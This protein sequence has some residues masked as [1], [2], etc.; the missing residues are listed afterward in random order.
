M[1]IKR[2]NLSCDILVVGGGIGGLTCAVSLKEQLPDADILVIEKQTAGYG[3]KAN[4]GGGVLQYF[5]P[6]KVDPV[7]FLGF[8]VNAIG[9][10]L[11]DQELMLKYVKMNKYMLDTLCGWGVNVPKKED[12]SYHVMP[13]G[14]FTAMI[15]VD[16]DITLRIRK[17]AEKLGVRFMDKTT[18]SDLFTQDGKIV[19]AAAYSILDGTYYAISAKN[20]VLATGSQNYRVG[21]M[22]SSGRGDGIAAAYRA[23]AEMR[24]VEFGNFAQL[25]R[26]RS[27]NEVVF[28]EN[29]MYNAKGEHIS[30]NFL[31]TRE[32]DINSNAI[33]EWYIQMMAGDGPVHLEFPAPP[34]G[35]AGGGGGSPMDKMWTQPYGWKFRH[36]NDSTGAKV[37]VDME[38]CPMLIG[39][40]S[41]VN[42]DHDMQTSIPGLFAV[43]DCSYSGSGLAGAVPAPP[44]RNRGSGILNAVFAG[45]LAAEGIVRIGLPE[46][47]AIAEE[48][49]ADSIRRVYAPLERE[50]GCTAKEVIAVVQKAMAPMEQSVYMKADRMEKAMA[51]VQEAKAMVPS[52]KADDFHGLLSCHE[53]EA[54]VLSAEM[55]YRTSALRKESRG[56]FLRED[57]P[58]MDNANWLKWIIVKNCDGEMT[59]S[60]KDLPIENW[61]IKPQN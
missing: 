8:H 26:V 46:A 44:G 55:H 4:K 42:V 2:E 31:K 49:I 45:L 38:V 27:H 18:M 48:Q 12:G 13:T 5:D 28:G 57:Y 9:A 53:A 20:V 51:L 14:P 10:Y 35:G 50:S 1:E 16:L 24:N 60:T 56:W 41:P 61:P 54:M 7:Q 11:G 34:G 43:G 3:G 23:G 29:N 15:R 32:T 21:S 47:V 25:V 58:E 40:Q 19:G 37:D 52:M 36:L 59:F 39:E 17:R 22:W 30:K 33:R 6:E